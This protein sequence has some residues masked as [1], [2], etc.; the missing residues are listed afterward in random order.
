MKWK[1]SQLTPNRD[2]PS[3]TYVLCIP[4]QVSWQPT[5][6]WSLRVAL[7]TSCRVALV[8]R[9][10]A[11]LS[12]YPFRRVAFSVRY[13]L[14]TWRVVQGLARSL[15][16]FDHSTPHQVSSLGSCKWNENEVLCYQLACKLSCIIWL[17]SEP[18]VCTMCNNEII[19][20]FSHYINLLA[21][22]SQL[23]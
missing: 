13:I 5:P 16:H 17:I 15:N 18:L 6:Y 8:V 9:T 7:G 3:S 22:G 10:D 23:A 11:S 1:H 12:L 20:P 14:N 19:A 21:L 2:G 4:P